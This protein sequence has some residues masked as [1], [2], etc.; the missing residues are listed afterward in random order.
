MRQ[1]DRRPK[2]LHPGEQAPAGTQTVFWV[3]DDLSSTQANFNGKEPYGKG[4]KGPRL[5][6]TAIVGSY[7]PNAFG[8]YDTIGNVGEWCQDSYHDSYNNAPADGSAWETGADPEIRIYRGGAYDSSAAVA[9]AFGSSW[10]RIK[11]SCPAFHIQNGLA[12]R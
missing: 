3:G 11:N 12:G 2:L 1:L 10:R 8:L 9:L 5:E 7:K 6:K 4:E